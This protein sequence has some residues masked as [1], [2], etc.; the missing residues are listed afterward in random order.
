[1]HDDWTLVPLMKNLHVFDWV[2]PQGHRR[3]QGPSG[4]CKECGKE[5]TRD[6]VWIAKESPKSVSY[7]FD[8]TPHFQ[9]FGEYSKRPE[10]QGDI[11]ETMSLQGSCWMLTRDKY[12][13]LDVCDENFGSWGS[14][15]IEVAVKTWLSGGQ[16]MC[17]HKTWYAHMF[18]T[19]GGDFGFP[20]PISGKDQEHAKSYARDLFFNNKWPRQVRPLSWLVNKF[21]PVKGWTEEDL[22]KLKTAESEPAGD[23]LTKG[24]IY[25]TDS[26]LDERIAKPVRDQLTKISLDKNIPIVSASLK[27]LAFGVKNIHFPLLK[28]GHLTMFRQ[29]LGALE[30]SSADIIFFCEHDVLYHPS[31]FDFTPPKKDAYHYNV[32]VWKVR[33]KDGH[34]LKINDSKQLSGLCGYR[35]FLIEHYKKRINIVEQRQR[36]LK[37]AGLPI[38]NDGV[39]KYMGYEPGL[40]SEPRGVD[41]FPVESWQSEYP[42]IDIRHAQN[43]TPNRWSRD[44]FKDQKHTTGWTESTADKIPGWE[45]ILDR[46]KAP[47]KGI[48]YYT[49]NRLNLKIAHAVQKQLEKARLPIVSAS[50]KKMSFGTKNIH[51]PHLKRGYLTMAKQILSALEHSKSE[52]IFFCEHDVLYHPSHF[53]FVPPRKD[54]YYYNTNVWK[55]RLEDGHALRV[56]DCR[57]L[58]GLCAYREL[59]IEHFKKRV[60][61][62]EKK[63]YSTAIGFEPGT[64]NRPDRVDDYKSEKWDSAS[65]NIDI[66]H[67]GNLTPSRWKKEL[68]RGQHY[69]AGWTENHVN[70]IPGW[71]NLKL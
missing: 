23:E 28:R 32:N 62:I 29:I 50:L 60:D 9:Y 7:C 69:T 71:E 6:V 67:G 35:Q 3:Y 14:Q 30:N 31:H 66:R 46:F 17:N 1:M 70:Q 52:T 63:G 54:M 49:D 4:P 61:R 8:S 12:W 16:V 22:V 19:Q 24:I 36:N 2:C 41:H 38:K 20:Y 47:N 13:E 48:I 68:F 59:L 5:T 64:H 56:D 34:S 15:G 37:A 44:Q 39:S 45:K 42:N 58:S 51:F 21:W 10:G 55:V 25:Y 18:R 26:E 43:F 11:T 53:D 40:H 57:Q 65:P 33:L 27:K